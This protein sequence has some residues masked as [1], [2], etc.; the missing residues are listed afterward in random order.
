MRKEWPPESIQLDNDSKVLFLTKDLSLIRKQLYEGLQLKM[1]DLNV[2]D[3]LDEIA[4]LRD[5]LK[6]GRDTSPHYFRANT[7]KSEA[8]YLPC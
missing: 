6:M 2:E 4:E 8:Q 1:K 3:L 7:G 5:R